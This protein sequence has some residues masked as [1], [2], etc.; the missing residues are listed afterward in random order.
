MLDR[1]ISS[2]E[3]Y[4]DEVVILD[5]SAVSIIDDGSGENDTDDGKKMHEIDA[6]NISKTP[7]ANGAE[8]KSRPPPS[9][10]ITSNM[11][12]TNLKDSSTNDDDELP[13]LANLVAATIR[14][15][16]VLEQ[17]EQI[18]ALQAQLSASQRVEVTGP[19]GSPVYARGCFSKGDFNSLSLQSLEDGENEET[20][21]LYWDVGLEMVDNEDDG[22]N[23]SDTHTIDQAK[24]VPLNKLSAIEIRIGGVLYVTS[25]EVE[26]TSM[27]FGI[28]P[29]NKFD[30]AHGDMTRSA[31]AEFNTE[32]R[33]DGGR[34]ALLTFHVR[35][36][37]RGH[38][39]S[40]Q[41][42]AMLN[43]S[44]ALRQAEREE[45]RE[46]RRELRS[47]RRMER[48]AEI[49]EMGELG[50]LNAPY[51]EEEYESD[52]EEEDEDDQDP[53]DVYNYLTLCLSKR[54]PEQRTDITSVSLCAKSVR[55]RIDNLRRGDEFE[56]VKERVFQKIDDAYRVELDGIE[57][58]QEE[59]L[60][61]FDGA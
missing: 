46:E 50:L 12:N 36:F 60:E 31:V 43:R 19:N 14:D 3:C 52:Y 49:A 42:V 40:L 24:T 9:T 25:S 33:Y 21:G 61:T 34:A 55:G 1:S 54:H 18:R 2:C 57:A 44:I 15:R 53:L 30:L 6:H 10:I 51:D 37:P 8:H 58:E 11:A 22:S 7:D 59:F 29:G 39:R 26:G 47:A 23:N 32:D 41:S 28:R 56:C 16:V 13:N 4:D 35:D 48:M 20:M 38:W 27:A 45:M 17:M 5:A